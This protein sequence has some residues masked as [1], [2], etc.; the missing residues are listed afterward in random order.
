VTLRDQDGTPIECQ[1]PVVALCRCG[2][3]RTRPFCD[4]TH[5][6]I[7]F[8]AP[9]RHEQRAL[10]GERGRPEPRSAAVPEASAD[11]YAKVGLLLARAQRSLDALQGSVNDPGTVRRQ[12]IADLRTA[13]QQLQDGA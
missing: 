9:S 8:S 4:G 3:S 12:L 1:R 13:A 10:D 11:S 5:Q 6:L 7:R 2:K